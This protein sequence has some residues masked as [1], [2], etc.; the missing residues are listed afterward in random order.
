MN[1]LR[2][3][4]IITLFILGFLTSILVKGLSWGAVLAV[5]VL[6]IFLI[7]GREEGQ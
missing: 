7:I 4:H 1:G 6:F 2:A 5:V 3:P